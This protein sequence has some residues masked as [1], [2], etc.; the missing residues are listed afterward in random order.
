MRDDWP[1]VLQLNDAD[2]T[3]VAIAPSDHRVAF[4]GDTA[5]RLWA[6]S[7]GGDVWKECWQNTAH[8]KRLDC[9]CVDPTDANRI[10]IS[11]SKTE[12]SMLYRV[13]RTANDLAIF[14]IG[15]QF[16]EPLHGIGRHPVL[17]DGLFTVSRSTLLW[18]ADGRFD[19]Q[20]PFANLPT[21]TLMDMHVVSRESRLALASHGRAVWVTAI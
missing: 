2:F 5:G 7:D 14:P 13:D 15:D 11:M 6:S 3:C 9:I 16:A 8:M 20:T 17:E 12:S 1:V 19:S 18:S 4:A 10:F 21:A